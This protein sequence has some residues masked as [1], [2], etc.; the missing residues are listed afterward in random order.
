ML[1]QLVESDFVLVLGGGE[2]LVQQFVV[3]SVD[4]FQVP[5]DFVSG[6]GGCLALV[7]LVD[8]G[9]DLHLPRLNLLA[10]FHL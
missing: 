1:D 10:V 4:L 7:A 9:E 6:V 5:L 8:E 2:E 3:E